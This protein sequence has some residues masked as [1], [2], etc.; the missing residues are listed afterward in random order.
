MKITSKAKALAEKTSGAYSFDRFRNWDAVIQSVLNLGY[1]EMETEAIVRSKWARW[2]CDHDTGFGGRYG[3]HT[4]T[5]MVR[6]LKGTPQSE[7]ND[8]VFETFGY[9][10]N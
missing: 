10:Q 4:S 8:L 7:V 9:S 6:F 3:Y 5:A 1:N 2:A